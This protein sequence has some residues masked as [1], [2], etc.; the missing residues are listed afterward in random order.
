MS[1]K[2]KTIT[3]RKEALH[4]TKHTSSTFI[5]QNDQ[6]RV[7]LDVW[8]NLARSHRCGKIFS[9][10]RGWCAFVKHVGWRW[11]VKDVRISNFP[12]F[13]HGVPTISNCCCLPPL[14]YSSESVSNKISSAWF[15]CEMHRSG[16][17]TGRIVLSP[18][19]RTN[20][21][22]WLLLQS[23]ISIFIPTWH[24]RRGS[25]PGFLHCKQYFSSMSFSCHV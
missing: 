10:L 20:F 16:D 1:R 17:I 21:C 24:P 5:S 2:S 18:F 7:Q 11:L 9:Y 23:S 12:H 3:H 19:T 25:H 14:Q 13:C 4:Q 15:W 22:R 8:W 6:Y